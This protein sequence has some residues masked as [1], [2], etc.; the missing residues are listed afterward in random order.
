MSLTEAEETKILLDILKI[1]KDILRMIY[2]AQSGH[3]G[4]SL[5]CANILYILY[6]KIM[7]IDRNNPQWKDRDIFILSK[8]HAAPALYAVL[9][10]V[11][12]FDRNEL[13]TLREF[14]SKLQGHPVKNNNLGIEITEGPIT[15]PDGGVMLFI[16]DQDRNVI[17]F[18]QSPSS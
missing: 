15:L 14:G 1:K 16:R 17:E 12:F 6:H 3:L 18:H 8:G 13:F 5:S 10:K 9:S 7:R 4:G 2:L 11:G